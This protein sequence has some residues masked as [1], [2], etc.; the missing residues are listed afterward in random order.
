MAEENIRRLCFETSG[1]LFNEFE[2]IFND[3]FGNR[4]HIY[5]KIIV[6]LSSGKVELATIYKN[7][8]IEKSGVI[9]QYLDDLI[10]S[11]FVRRDFSWKLGESNKSKLS[12]YR[13]SDNYLR[14]YIKNIAPYKDR[15]IRGDFKTG[16]TNLLA[17]WESIMGLQF[18]NLVLNNRKL[19]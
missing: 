17:S 4:S 2:Q 18:E 12:T 10:K 7:L 5:K 6:C 9:S 13:I 11:G 19:V 8:D 16:V 15:I 14:F 3:I 1:L